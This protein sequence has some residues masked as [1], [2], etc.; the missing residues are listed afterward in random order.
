[1]KVCTYSPA[2]GKALNSKSPSTHNTVLYD[3]PLYQVM[4][5]S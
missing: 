4:M 3:F 1:M 5:F 2:A